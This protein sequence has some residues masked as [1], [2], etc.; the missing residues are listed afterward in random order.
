VLQA[1]ITESRVHEIAKRLGLRSRRGRGT[2]SEQSGRGASK[3]APLVPLQLAA[4]EWTRLNGNDGVQAFLSSESTQPLVAAEE[5]RLG[6]AIHQGRHEQSKA[7]HEQDQDAIA[8]ATRAQEQLSEAL[9]PLVFSRALSMLGRQASLEA[10]LLAGRSGLEKAICAFDYTDAVPLVSLALPAVNQAL[11]DLIEQTRSSLPA[12]RRTMAVRLFVQIALASQRLARES[13][14]APTVQ[15]LAQALALSQEVVE[16]TITQLV[17][18]RPAEV[19]RGGEGVRRR[20]KVTEEQFVA[21][22]MQT[23]GQRSSTIIEELSGVLPLTPGSIQVKFYQLRL[24][25]RLAERECARPHQQQGDLPTAS[26]PL[27]DATPDATVRQESPPSRDDHAGAACDGT[28][29]M[30]GRRAAVVRQAVDRFEMPLGN[31]LWDVRIDGRT[32]RWTLG[33]PYGDLD[34]TVSVGT[35]VIFKSHTYRVE[36]MHHSILVVSSVQA[37]GFSE[38]P[39]SK[40][41]AL[42]SE[43]HEMLITDA[44]TRQGRA[45]R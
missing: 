23:Q 9:F 14:A 36:R 33:I 8:T 4:S 1:P 3:D 34:S 2:A 42:R 22:F 16:K 45:G 19:E 27:V 25:G 7:P 39:E 40:S 44:R 32:E 37:E 28:R 41:V 17:L 15:A 18:A 13:G 29:S 38:E 20:S 12:S 26:H 43:M 11:D 5:I 30:R 31:W 6:Y 24:Q 35:R 10:L 21:A